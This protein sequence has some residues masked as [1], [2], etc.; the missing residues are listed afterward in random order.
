MKK[1]DLK[2]P[3]GEFHLEWEP[4]SEERFN[5]ICLLVGIGIGS[6]TFIEFFKMMV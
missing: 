2:L 4:M 6:Y 3:D 1:I 5:V